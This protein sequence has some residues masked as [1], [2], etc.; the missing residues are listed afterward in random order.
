M[1]CSM[2]TATVILTRLMQQNHHYC[3][4]I[5]LHH[6]HCVATDRPSVRSGRHD[7]LNHHSLP[8]SRRP[9]D[10]SASHD[11]TAVTVNLMHRILQN[12]HHH[13]HFHR[14]GKQNCRNHHCF[15]TRQ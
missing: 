12:H 4:Q 8:Q 15:G 14:N 7:D 6:C 11:S 10:C 1:D 3:C 5:C 13:S 9:S 2:A